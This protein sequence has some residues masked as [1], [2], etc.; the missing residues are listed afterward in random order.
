MNE[1]VLG[2]FEARLVDGRERLARH[3]DHS[4]EAHLAEELDNLGAREGE[5][6]AGVDVG[7]TGDKRAGSEVGGEDGAGAAGGGGRVDDADGLDAA[8]G[9]FSDGPDAE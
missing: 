9:G 4:V 1:V 7:G 2:D 8:K 3:G 5:A 6:G